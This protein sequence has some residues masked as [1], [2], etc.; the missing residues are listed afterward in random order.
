[1][2]KINVKELKELFIEIRHGNNMG[3][4]KLYNR[5]NKLVYRIAFSILKNKQD[6][7]DIVQI[8]FTKIYSID[9]NKLP[10]RNEASWLYSITKNETINYLRGKNNNINID[11]IYEIE[12]N[13]NEINRIIDQDNYNKLISKLN[14]KEKEIISLK[15]LSNLSFEEI[16]KVLNIPTGTIKWKYYKSIHTLRVLLSSLGMFVISFVSSIIVFKN[17]S[18]KSDLI[19]E[20]VSD[21]EDNNLRENEE[22]EGSPTEEKKE[23]SFSDDNKEQIQENVIIDVP[24]QNNINYIGIGFMGI[25]SF[26]FIITIFFSII[27]TKHQLKGRK[28]LSK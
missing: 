11:S 28:K 13:N 21:T 4:E 7:E 17:G 18:K 20:E 16:G 1:M 12:D 6:T 26:F 27:F 3:F 24:V 14:D 2:E 19:K 25:S 8:I 9:K 15:V 10:N 23:N 5:Y 22:I